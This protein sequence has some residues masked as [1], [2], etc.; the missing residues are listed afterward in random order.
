M[1]TGRRPTSAAIAVKKDCYMDM[2]SPATD[3]INELLVKIIEFTQARRKII[4]QNM[5]NVHSPA[6]AP[7][8][9]TARELGRLLNDAVTEYTRTKRLLFRDTLNIKFG[10]GGSFTASALADEH[11]K[12][13]LETDPDK[14]LEL[15]VN[16]LIENELNQR[17]A[18]E[19]LRQREGLRHVQAE[20]NRTG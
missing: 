10:P 9:L 18:A 5:N 13:L 4:V 20:A 16:K 12:K 15:Q 6:F 2:P 17:L 1:N 8:D 14:Y 11:A 3:G 7:K 19:I